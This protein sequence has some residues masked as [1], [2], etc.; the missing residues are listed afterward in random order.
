VPWNW[1]LI[2]APFEFQSFTRDSRGIK[3]WM[4]PG[5]I[6]LSVIQKASKTPECELYDVYFFGNF[7]QDAGVADDGRAPF[8]PDR[9]EALLA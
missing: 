6:K 3:L 5:C 8:I 7:A 2:A 4:T 1:V 9:M